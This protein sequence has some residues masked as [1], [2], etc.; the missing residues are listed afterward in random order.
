MFTMKQRSVEFWELLLSLREGTTL[1]L[2]GVFIMGVL[3]M[4]VISNL[5]FGL[6]TDAGSLGW[7]AV[8][9]VA[10]AS[11]VI[12]M[13][14]YGIYWRERRNLSRVHVILDESR[15]ATPHRGL[16]WLLGP[17]GVEHALQAI[18]H[19]AGGQP[20]QRLEHCWLVMQRDNAAIQNAYTTLASQVVQENW[21]VRLEPIL[22]DRLDV[23]AAYGAVRRVFERDAPA[24]GL[25]ERDVIADIT[26]AT[27]PMTTG[28]VLA[29]LDGARDLEYVESQRDAKGDPIAGTLRVV[30][31]N[32]T[33]RLERG[34]D[35]KV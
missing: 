34:R 20:G 25:S 9:R 16:I 7:G 31:V 33:F 4:G 13:L 23:E 5:V 10:V 24:V 30:G 15:L 8:L 2:L 35:L 1:A 14:A 26:G 6:L 21:G 11:G 32:K 19:H 22:I 3:V 18:R 29:A 12:V 28:M 17:G 27:K